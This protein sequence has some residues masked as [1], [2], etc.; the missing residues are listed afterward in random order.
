ME[1]LAECKLL[2]YMEHKVQTE[3]EFVKK[4]EKKKGR[5][6]RRRKYNF[7]ASPSTF[8]FRFLKIRRQ[9]TQR[10]HDLPL[11]ERCK[12]PN[13]MMK[14]LAESELVGW[15]KH[16]CKQTK[17]ATIIQLF[18][19]PYSKT[20][21]LCCRRRRPTSA[22]GERRKKTPVISLQETLENWWGE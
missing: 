2:G 6:R 1:L 14:L 18:A 10:H 8:K 9:S 22:S 16:K 20:T 15:T 5:R 13:L 3:K 11:T 12:T 4:K 7:Y 17:V 19:L 21:N